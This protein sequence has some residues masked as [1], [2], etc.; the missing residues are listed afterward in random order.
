MFNLQ[1]DHNHRL[2]RHSRGTP[3]PP[4][5]EDT[6]GAEGSRLEP[7]VFIDNALKV[8]DRLGPRALNDVYHQPKPMASP[9]TPYDPH[10]FLKGCITTGGGDNYHYA[11]KRRYTAREM[12]LFQSFPYHYQFSGRPTQAMKQV[13]N[14]F[15]PVIAEAMYKTI[16]MALAAYDDGLISAEDDLTNLDGVFAQL[17]LN[18][19]TTLPTPQELSDIFSE[20]A[21]E[22]NLPSMTSL[23]DLY[24]GSRNM[25]GSFKDA[26]EGEDN[27]DDDDEVVFLG[28]SRRTT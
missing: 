3:L 9:K 24:D 4:F 2:T 16:I 5:P 6:H 27:D 20:A 1:E 12:S 23:N 8:M 21:T 25:P 7:F 10:N 11:G 15:P 13:G 18:S 28:S 19:M 17:R 22:P 14:A 26:S